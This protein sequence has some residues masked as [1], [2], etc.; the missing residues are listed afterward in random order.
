MKMGIKTYLFKHTEY[1]RG[2][3][4]NPKY[5]KQL[6]IIIAI[7][8]FAV[9]I[10][11][12][13][14]GPLNKNGITAGAF[15]KSFF[16]IFVM[17]F[18]A[19]AIGT[20]VYYFILKGMLKVNTDKKTLFALYSSACIPWALSK[21]TS[22]MEIITMGTASKSI[23]GSAF[24]GSFDIFILWKMWIWYGC[25]HVIFELGKRQSFTILIFVWLLS[26]VANVILYSVGI[27]F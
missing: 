9:F 4:R 3:K 20:E 24:Y 10:S 13:P 25:L 18:V 5:K 17:F 23:L 21:L 12:T 22:Q 14:G 7:L 19:M 15:L 27:A 26:L 11:L 8:A 2:I 16:S 1:L 6:I